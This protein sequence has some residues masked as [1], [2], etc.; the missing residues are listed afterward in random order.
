[1]TFLLLLLIGTECEKFLFRDCFIRE[2][3]SLNSGIVMKTGSGNEVMVYARLISH[4]YDTKALEKILKIK[5]V[6]SKNACALCRKVHGVRTYE[7][8]NVVYEGSR[9]LLRENHFLRNK[10]LSQQCCPVGYYRPDV[11]SESKAF[12]PLPQTVP[13]ESLSLSGCKLKINQLESCELSVIE[14]ERVKEM[15]KSSDAFSWHHHSVEV[16]VFSAF[17]YYHHA[18]YRPYTAYSRVSNEVYLNDGVEAEQFSEARR[19]KQ[20]KKRARSALQD[21]DSNNLADKN[22]VLGIWDFA[23]LSYSDVETQI[24]WD[25]FHAAKGV[26]VDFLNLLCND[27][28]QY[29]NNSKVKELA[30]QTRSHPFLHSSSEIALVPL[31]KTTHTSNSSQQSNN[32]GTKKATSTPPPP[33]CLKAE[34]ISK[35]DEAFSQHILLAPSFG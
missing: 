4:T 25:F 3:E 32:T 9:H 26:L 1:M 28:R 8:G 20:Q 11:S 17:L 13:V 7:L 10:G 33:W 29:T 5:S 34:T 15:L 12:R 24:C 27:G 16:T 23:R 22:G 14:N 6:M 18:D 19:K 31:P 21:R 30:V 2:L 35:L